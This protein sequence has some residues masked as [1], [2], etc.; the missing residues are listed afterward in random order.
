MAKRQVFYSF[1]YVPDNWRVAQVRN[2]WVIE[3][4]KPASDNDWEEVT[5]WWDKAIKKWIDENLKWRS[6]SVVLIWEKTAWRKW[7]KYEIEQSRNN[8]KWLV[9][10][11]I[12]N[13]KN[14]DWDQSNKGKNP[15]DSFTIWKDENKKKLSDIIKTYDPPY[16]TST[17][18]Y[19]H[20]QE[21][22]ESWIEEAISIRENYG[23]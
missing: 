21:N 7:I 19:N 4:N 2:I 17:N 10:I 13:L 12:H 9:W 18:V 5:K 11:Y 8:K 6:C 14:K 1:H 20:I 23:K 3:W 15:F 16:T 22:L